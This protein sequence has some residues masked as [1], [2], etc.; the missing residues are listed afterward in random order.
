VIVLAVG[1]ALAAVIVHGRPGPVAGA[2]SE[3]LDAAFARVGPWVGG[4]RELL[5]KRIE[6]ALDLDDYTHRPY[7]L[8]GQTVWLYVGYHLRGES[9]GAAHSPLVCYPGQGWR[10]LDQEKMELE[11]RGLPLRLMRLTVVKDGREDVVLFWFQAHGRS[12]AGSFRQKVIAFR[13]RTFYGRSDSA[14]VR[15]SVPV[16]ADGR[17]AALATGLS[18][19]EAFYPR[20]HQYVVDQDRG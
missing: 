6:E 7:T 4:E 1:L 16:G 10:I 8:D 18:F 3:P 12:T 13:A 9:I 11:C 5:D 14:F 17:G 2:R 15:V 19:I 20:F